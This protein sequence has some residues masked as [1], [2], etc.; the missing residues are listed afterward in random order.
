MKV[1][2]IENG[3][4]ANVLLLSAATLEQFRQATGQTLIPIP[5]GED[6]VV[7]DLY[8]A[9]ENAFHRPALTWE[10]GERPKVVSLAEMQRQIE[11]LQEQVREL[12]AAGGA[13]DK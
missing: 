10:E 12:L 7:G 2:Q 3:E 9:E 1:A 5:E 6:V 4:V 11:A 8:D 13:E